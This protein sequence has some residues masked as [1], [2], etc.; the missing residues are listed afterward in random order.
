MDYELWC[1]GPL[2]ARFALTGSNRARNLFLLDGVEAWVS[3]R[4]GEWQ[5]HPAEELR[6]ETALRWELLR[7]PWGWEMEIAAAAPDSRSFTRATE[8]GT[9]TVELAPDGRPSGGTCGAVRAAI[10]SWTALDGRTLPA[11]W[12]WSGPSGERTEEF[13]AMADRARFFDAAF[14][15][16]EDEGA[17]LVRG[18]E[19]RLGVISA[20]MW[21]VAAVAPAPA[22]DAPSWWRQ[23]EQRIAAVL[24][25]AEAT[26]PEPGAAALPGEWWLRWSFL[27][28]AADARSAAAQ[29][30]EAAQQAGLE[31][32][33]EPWQ[34]EAPD[35]GRA[36]GQIVVLAVAAPPR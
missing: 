32:L 29:L 10:T 20:R 15:P 14:R 25:D 18:G 2:R 17:T 9:V 5:P 27:G 23:G 21:R 13:R 16:P 24:L 8:A 19:E 3:T 11:G 35:D 12:S 6:A 33:G 1:A 30:R 34:R 26:A 36:H 7:F 4:P 22:M 28:G 31:P